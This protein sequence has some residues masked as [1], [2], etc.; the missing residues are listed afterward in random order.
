MGLVL[1]L[2]GC[3][4]GAAVAE[5]ERFCTAIGQQA[6]RCRGGDAIASYRACTDT[7]E[8][9]RTTGI[10][11]Q[12]QLDECIRAVGNECSALLPLE[13]SGQFRR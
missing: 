2:T 11:D 5:C 3:A 4:D 10:R 12:A 8:C 7:L 6:A 1:F 13:C 9:G